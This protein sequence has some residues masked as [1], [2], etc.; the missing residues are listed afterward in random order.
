MKFFLAII[1]IPLLP[2]ILFSQPHVQKNNS[3]DSNP[4]KVIGIQ[5]IPANYMIV[6]ARDYSGRTIQFLGSSSQHATS[7]SSA[8]TLGTIMLANFAAKTISPLSDTTIKYKIVKPVFS[9]QCCLISII[10]RDRKDSV[11]FVIAKTDTANGLTYFSMKTLT[12]DLPN[13]IAIGKPIYQM[14]F[15]NKRYATLKPLDELEVNKNIFYSYEFNFI[16]RESYNTLRKVKRDTNFTPGNKDSILSLPIVDSSKRDL[17][18][19]VSLPIELSEILLGKNMV[20]GTLTVVVPVNVE[21]TIKI[22]SLPD[23][24]LLY[25]SNKQQNFSLFPG[26]YEIEISGMI[27]KN[28]PVYKGMDTRLKAGTLSIQYNLP[29]VIYDANKVKIIYRSPVADKV[30]FPIGIYQL[31]IAGILHPIEIKDGETLEYDSTKQIS[32]PIKLNIIDSN[33]IVQIPKSK[34]SD[35]TNNKIIKDETGNH[36]F[37]EKKWEIKPNT[38]IKNATGRIFIKIPKDIECIISISQPNTGKEVYYS[39]ALTNQRSFSLAPGTVDVKISGSTIKNV[40]VQKGMETRVKAGILNVVTSEIWTL[41]D[42]KKSK[43]IYFSTTAKK[44]GLPIG[45]Y[46]IEKN[47]RTEQI[48]IKDSEILQF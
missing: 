21:Y 11:D 14:L 27:L 6:S 44:I 25:N 5:N 18:P 38:S 8:L 10:E 13:I 33:K 12:I 42:E 40:P 7:N 47:G 3:F 15:N 48:K 30:K 29:W 43:Q 45:I 19:D 24:T 39:G 20:T 46:Q 17:S 36:L 1:I 23:H 9:Y 4:F 31:E 2:L 35:S 37:D 22:Y 28:I 41:Y 26:M 34:I 32:K 16:T